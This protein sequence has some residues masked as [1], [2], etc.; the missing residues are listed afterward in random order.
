[1]NI[2]PTPTLQQL[3]GAD[4][5]SLLRLFDHAKGI[6]ATS[7]AQHERAR[8]DRAIRRI[9]VELQRRNVRP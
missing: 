1:M 2:F 9:A 3:R 8:A 4:S 6:L 7:K 5:N